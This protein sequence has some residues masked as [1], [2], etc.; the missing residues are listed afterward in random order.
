MYICNY[1]QVKSMRKDAAGNRPEPER[2][3]TPVK[4]TT[5][6][7]QIVEEE[8]VEVCARMYV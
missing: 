3:A 5:V 7:E 8:V 1:I 6:K 2:S 4:V